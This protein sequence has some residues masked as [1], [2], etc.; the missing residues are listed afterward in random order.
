M[1]VE[2]KNT[3]DHL[4][5]I[6]HNAEKNMSTATSLQNMFDFTQAGYTLKATEIDGVNAHLEELPD[7][8]EPV[9][10]FSSSTIYGLTL[11]HSVNST[12]ELTLSSSGVVTATGVAIKTSVFND[13]KTSLSSSVN[14]IDLLVLLAGGTVSNLVMT[15]VNLQVDTYIQS[16]SQ[17]LPG[18][19][20]EIT[21][22]YY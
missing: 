8:L 20:L 10:V 13:L 3:S 2:A 17:F 16:Q 12:T 21:S 4:M 14:P 15:H 6:N 7:P 1:N 5:Q 19:Q 9:L 11:S 22:I 18:F